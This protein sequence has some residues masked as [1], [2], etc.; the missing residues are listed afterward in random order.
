[1]T[2]PIK[3]IRNIIVYYLTPASLSNMW[4]FGAAAFLFLASQLITGILLVTVY[5]PHIDFAAPSIEHL[6]RDILTG[7]LVRYLHISGASFFFFVL[8]AHIG[9]GINFGSFS[10][11]RRTVW[12]SGSIIFYLGMLTAFTGY[13]LPWGQMSYWAATV[14]TNLL[15]IFP[16]GT[17]LVRLVWGSSTINTG[18]LSRFFMIHFATPLVIIFLVLLHI[19]FLHAYGSGNPNSRSADSYDASYFS[20]FYI[21]KDIV[22]LGLLVLLFIISCIYYPL[23]LAHPDNYVPANP[24]VTPNHIVP[25]WY[26]LPVYAILRSCATKLE[27]IIA[28]ASA[29]LILLSMAFLASTFYKNGFGGTAKSK[30]FLS[31]T[32]ICSY[33]LLMYI[34]ACSVEYPFV[35]LGEKISVIYFFVLAGYLFNFDSKIIKFLSV[36]SFPKE[37]VIPVN[38]D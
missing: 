16:R 2:L 36:I 7:W 37:L 21:V 26:F 38:Y 35:D 24:F 25:E 23:A 28:F 5:I 19:V 15:T 30:I 18:T 32:L 20:P 8:Y 4:S 29:I 14:I 9:R 11:P 13:I 27:G 10:Y 31:V 12:F 22:A 33:L 34:G 3:F 1:M 6:Q 17:E